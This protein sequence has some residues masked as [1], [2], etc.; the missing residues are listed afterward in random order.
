M[1]LVDVMS[2]EVVQYVLVHYSWSVVHVN[3]VERATADL[4]SQNL[5]FELVIGVEDS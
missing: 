3:I 2:F 4:F 1:G 5:V